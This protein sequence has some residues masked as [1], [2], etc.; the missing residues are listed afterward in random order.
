MARS[1]GD[2][3][4][5]FDKEVSDE[6][7]GEPRGHPVS[8]ET[9][10]EAI[11]KV[12]DQSN[13]ISVE[14]VDEVLQDIQVDAER[15]Y[16]DFIH[17]MDKNEWN[18][19]EEKWYANAG[20]FLLF[21]CFNA[22]PQYWFGTFT[23][24]DGRTETH[25]LYTNETLREVAM[26]AHLI[27]VERQI[28]KRSLVGAGTNHQL[29]LRWGALIMTKPHH[30]NG[31][32]GMAMLPLNHLAAAELSAAEILDYFCVEIH[33]RRTFAWAKARGVNTEAVNQNIRH[34]KE[35]LNRVYGK[36]GDLDNIRDISV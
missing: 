10:Q 30:F 17:Q 12:C 6:D 4:P 29:E 28:E 23:G 33:G 1:R 2:M 24:E 11:V 31:G 36:T 32:E 21:D 13:M 27:E 26:T 34:A 20:P 22:T 16:R 14:E 5:A 19:P 18:Y 35:K 3:W 8:E 9:I 15:V 7:E 25:P